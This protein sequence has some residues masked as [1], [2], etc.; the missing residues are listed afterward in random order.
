MR[1]Y[2]L[3]YVLAVFWGAIALVGLV[4]HR[5]GNAALEGAVAV[6]FIVIGI[7]VKRRDAAAAARYTAN[8][9]R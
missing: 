4:H 6:L 7:A 3:W 8:R 1:R 5:T 2:I 9:P